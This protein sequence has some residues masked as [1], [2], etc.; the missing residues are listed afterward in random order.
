[1]DVLSYLLDLVNCIEVCWVLQHS[2]IHPFVVINI[3]GVLCG[4]LLVNVMLYL[5]VTHDL[6][7]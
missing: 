6:F 7:K 4:V 2:L 1:M 5:S 3:N